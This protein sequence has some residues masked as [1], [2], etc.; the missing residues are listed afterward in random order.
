M[1]NRRKHRPQPSAALVT[2]ADG[3]ERLWHSLLRTTGLVRHAM[4]PHFS[5][6]GI[7]GPQWGVLRVLH[8]AEAAGNGEIRLS[9]LGER[10]LIRP[11]S[12]TG[13]VDRLERMGLVRRLAG[14]NDRRVRRVGLTA[15]GRSLVAEVQVGHPARIRS[16]FDHFTLREREQLRRLLDRLQARLSALRSPGNAARRKED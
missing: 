1:E 6:Y 8:G 14:G 10:L 13:V 12:V 2:K 11:P 16:L 9:D 5:R 7:S 15:A 3:A 4:Q